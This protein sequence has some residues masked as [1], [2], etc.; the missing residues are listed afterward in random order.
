MS[1]FLNGAKI[2]VCMG[3]G[4]VGKT[5]IASG[6]AALCA[7][8]GLKVLVLTVDPSKRLK[9][10][11]GLDES[12]EPR[13]VPLP[14]LQGPGELWG[15]VMNSQKT[16]D[17]FVRRASGQS[18]DAEKILQNRLYQQLSTT[19]S[20]SQEFTALENLLA[21]EKS[22][23]F[24]LIVLDTPPAHHAVE[25]LQ[26]PHKLA[27]IFNE[28]I[29]KWFRAPEGRGFFSGLFQAGTRQT[30]KILE[31]L[32]G[33]EF[34]SQL[35][36]FFAHIHSW[37]GQLESRAID[38]QR[39]LVRPT[40]R[41]LL[42]TAFDE[43]KFHE[44][45]A[46]AREIRKGGYNLAGIIINRAHPQWALDADEPATPAAAALLHDFRVYFQGRRQKIEALKKRLGAG[47]EVIEVPEQTA[48]ISSP[49]AVWE[50]SKLL[51]AAMPAGGTS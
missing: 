42:I 9:Q 15:A 31:S 13:R 23:R 4:G 41:F 10:S 6:L 40:T 29:A 8:R 28:G 24:D 18:P 19:L 33:A 30:L 44:G 21:A 2:I 27:T 45:E 46:F 25:F 22:G 51:E 26:A 17:D 37:Q 5:T 12:G 16:F 48:D 43:A 14:E 34:M 38:S 1:E 36:E 49:A 20:G 32:T 39:L 35:A 50:F 47:F 11:L 3:T 7:R